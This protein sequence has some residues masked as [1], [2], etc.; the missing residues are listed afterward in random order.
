MSTII[1]VGQI[2]FLDRYLQ[3]QLINGSI[4]MISIR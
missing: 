2:V 4:I 1:A 3:L